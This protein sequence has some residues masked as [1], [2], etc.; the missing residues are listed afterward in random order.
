MTKQNL[1]WNVYHRDINRNKIDIYNVFNHYSFSEEAAKL[2]KKKLTREKFSEELKGWAMYYF[3][4]KCEWE[5]IITSWPP[6][7]KE[8][9]LDIGE[10]IDVYDQLALNWDK[11]VDYVYE[12]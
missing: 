4:S 2:L 9:K 5:V 6:H 7:I 11:F 3:W 10:K 1:V 12:E 8:N